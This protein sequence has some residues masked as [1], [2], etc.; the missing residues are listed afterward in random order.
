[1]MCVGV[2]WVCYHNKRKT[3]DRND[4]KF[5]TVVILDIVLKHVH[6]GFKG[7]GWGLGLRCSTAMQIYISTEYTFQLLLFQQE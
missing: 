6:F 1:M 7:Q 3:P 5:G 2:M 4:L